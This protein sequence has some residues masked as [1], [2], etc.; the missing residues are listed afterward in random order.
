MLSDPI[1]PQVVK[2]E[3]DCLPSAEPRSGLGGFSIEV[4]RMNRRR[5]LKPEFSGVE[6]LKENSVT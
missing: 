1:K 4:S 2:H 3:T 6:H 5:G